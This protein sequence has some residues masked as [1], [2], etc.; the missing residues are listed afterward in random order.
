[1]SG[2]FVG[3]NFQNALEKRNGVTAAGFEL[4]FGGAFERCEVIGRD[5]EGLIVCGECFAIAAELR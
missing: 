5:R 3:P 1:V 4:Q 2:W